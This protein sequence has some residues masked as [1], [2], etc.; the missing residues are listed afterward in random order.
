MKQVTN[1]IRF[2]AP[3]MHWILERRFDFCIAVFFE[4]HVAARKVYA[5]DLGHYSVRQSTLG[6]YLPKTGKVDKLQ[7]NPLEFRE[8]L[9]EICRNLLKS[10]K[11]L[12]KLVKFSR[13]SQISVKLLQKLDEIG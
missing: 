5:G 8:K 12:E 3:H 1:R 13:I 2:D 4:I 7:R 11:S 6:E 9:P 10:W